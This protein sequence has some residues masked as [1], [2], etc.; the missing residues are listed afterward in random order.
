MTR[1]EHIGERLAAIEAGLKAAL[2]QRTIKR[3]LLHFSEHSAAELKRGVLMVVGDIEQGYRNSPGLISKD[4][5]LS[6]LLIAHLQVGDAASKL[7]LETAEIALAE[8]IKAFCRSGVAGLTLKPKSLQLSRQLA[9]P[10][11]FVVAQ[12][13]AWPLNS[14]V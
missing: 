3:A 12:I 2:P 5:V 10:Q 6:V 1:I 13:E 8:E 4:G 11:G 7:E 14:N 9:H